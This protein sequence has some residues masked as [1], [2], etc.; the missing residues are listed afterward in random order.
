M[1]HNG[2]EPTFSIEDL[3][4][5]EVPQPILVAGYQAETSNS[6]EY[7]AEPGQSPIAR[8]IHKTMDQPLDV[9]A[10]QPHPAAQMASAYTHFTNLDTPDP[11]YKYTMGMRVTAGDDLPEDIEIV[12]VP[13][14]QFLSLQVGGPFHTTIPAAWS[15]LLNQFADH[16][17]PYKR[18]FTGDVELYDFGPEP[19]DSICTIYVA[20]KPKAQ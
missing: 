1:N 2:S 15:W 10:M 17:V 12:E 14:G 4:L 13:A 20:V 6:I 11:L 18:T 8:V 5:V 9:R 7:N 16:T 19:G 3:H